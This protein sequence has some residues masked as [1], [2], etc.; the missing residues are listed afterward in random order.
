MTPLPIRPRGVAPVERILDRLDRVSERGEGQW[1]A[2]CPAHDDTRPSLSVAALHPDGRALVFCY[3]GC[4]TQAV[5][6]AIGLSMR[7]LFPRD[8]ASRSISRPRPKE[9]RYERLT[10]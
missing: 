10:W 5:M 6:E 7:D 1:S 8:S 2:C 4:E 3:A 9:A